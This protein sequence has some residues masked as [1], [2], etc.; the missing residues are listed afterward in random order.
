MFK[1]YGSDDNLG[2]VQAWFCEP[3]EFNT[4]DVVGTKTPDKLGATEERILQEPGDT[5]VLADSDG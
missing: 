3:M 4:D 1:N 2:I 5:E